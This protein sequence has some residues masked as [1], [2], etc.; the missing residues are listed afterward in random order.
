MI[1]VRCKVSTALVD[2]IWRVVDRMLEIKSVDS[3]IMRQEDDHKKVSVSFHPSDFACC[4]LTSPVTSPGIYSYRVSCWF[5]VQASTIT[6][7]SC[8]SSLSR[9][10]LKRMTNRRSDR[11]DSKRSLC[12][13]FSK[14]V[15]TRRSF[16]VL[17]FTVSLRIACLVLGR[18][19]CSWIL[20]EG[21]GRALINSC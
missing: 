17:R 13:I 21:K 10:L 4:L 12:D 3:L 7:S 1:Q 20:D 15:T 14:S 2:V 5:M 19:L 9:R 18:R 6:T 16:L 8:G 11:S